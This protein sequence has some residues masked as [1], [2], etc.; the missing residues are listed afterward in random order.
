MIVM[1]LRTWPRYLRH[2][3]AAF[4]VVG[5]AG[6]AAGLGYIAIV[7]GPTPED[8]GDHYEGNEAEMSFGKSTGEMLTIIHTHLLGMGVLFLAVGLLFAASDF[9]A[10]LKGAAMVE[11]ML[12]LFSTFGG[13]YFVSIGWRSWLWVVYPSSVLMVMGYLTMSVA[14]LG[15]AF[16]P[17]PVPTSEDPDCRS[18]D[19]YR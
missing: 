17:L 15:S 5:L 7:T 1:R 12:T 18:S 19:G 9:P 4:V 8:V 3:V 10:R 16:R 11:T 6:Y 2:F 14:I 13:L